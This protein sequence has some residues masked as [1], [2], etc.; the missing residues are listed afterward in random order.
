M[1]TQHGGE[2]QA[3]Q[4]QRLKEKVGCEKKSKPDVMHKTNKSGRTSDAQALYIGCTSTFCKGR[5][6]LYITPPPLRCNERRINLAVTSDMYQSGP[7]RREEEFCVSLLM[8]QRCKRC[9]HDECTNQAKK[10]GVCFMHGAKRKECSFEG[11][12][13]QLRKK[14]WSL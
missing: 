10:G 6:S 9:S 5:R 2:K 12:N 8:V 3:K 11:C 14:G 4:I 7:R 13:M 1:G